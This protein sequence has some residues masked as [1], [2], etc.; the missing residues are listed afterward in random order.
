MVRSL[1]PQRSPCQRPAKMGTFIDLITYGLRGGYIVS[2]NRVLIRKLLTLSIT[3][4]AIS[5]ERIS[6]ILENSTDI[7]Q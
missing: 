2:H 7:S 6:K 5:I 3:I 1:A 4:N